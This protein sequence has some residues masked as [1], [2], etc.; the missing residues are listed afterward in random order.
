MSFDP[1]YPPDQPPDQPP[2]RDDRPDLPPDEG[3]YPGMPPGYGRRS[4]E[5]AARDRVQ[6]P[7]IFLIVVAVLNLLIALYWLVDGLF[8]TQMPLAQFEQTMTARNP[9]LP[10]QLKQLGW[11]WEGVQKGFGYGFV[12]LGVVGVLVAF[13]GI[14]GGVRML[15]L[16]S[17]G[18][19]ILA[20]ILTA[21]P[22]LSGCAC[23]C[24]GMIPGVW[25]LIVLM[26]PDVR[27]AFR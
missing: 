18:V 8:V 15:Q 24:V 4:L 5:R 22:V 25:A 19:A 17:Y 11:T 21:V 12:A 7:A 20:S 26:N 14:W 16:R 2:P 1:S 9:D 6:L 13:L 23:A 3:Y 10:A 27:E